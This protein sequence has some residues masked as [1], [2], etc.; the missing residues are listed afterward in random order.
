M[1]NWRWPVGRVRAL[2]L[3]FFCL[4][5]GSREVDVLN[6]SIHFEAC[7][8]IILYSVTSIFFTY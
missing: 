5:A 1:E 4:G 2:R 6:S 7:S 3:W 8:S